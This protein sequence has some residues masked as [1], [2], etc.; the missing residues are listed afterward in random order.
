MGC[1]RIV[2]VTVATL[3]LLGSTAFTDVHKDNNLGFQVNTPAN[4]KN[5]PVA[6]TE[7]WI[8]A[9]YLSPKSYTSRKDAY[10]HTPDMK[11]ILFPEAVVKDRGV[12]VKK[13]DDKTSVIQIKNPYKDFKAYLAA[14]ASGGGF[15]I[16]KEEETTVAGVA[17]TCYEIK[18]EKLTVPRRSLAWVYHG[19]DADWAV[20]FEALEDH[21][22]KLSPDYVA[23]LRSFRFIKRE[24]SVI[25]EGASGT[26]ADDII[27]DLSKLSAE[28][29]AKRRS[30]KHERDL[31]K[32]VDRLPSGW[33]QKKSRNYVAL[34]HVDEKYTTWSLEQAEAI[35]GW[36]E[37]T[38]GWVG[39]GKAG[40]G[41]IRICEGSDEYRA[42]VDNSGGFWSASAE[43]VTY[44]DV[45]AG[46]RSNAVQS[47][48]RSIVGLWFADKNPHFRWGV[49]GW[50]ETGLD[51]FLMTAT[52][53]GGSLTFKADEWETTLMRETGKAGKLVKPRDLIRMSLEEFYRT[54]NS[55]PQAGAFV[56]YLLDGPGK[57]GARSKNFLRDYVKA[58]VSVLDEENA[59]DR[60]E[61]RV[62]DRP[63]TEEEEEER[64]KERRKKEKQRIQTV[65]DRAFPSWS[66]SDWQS[67]EKQYL[68]YV[69]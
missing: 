69:D 34:S 61:S 14:N 42:F 54:E 52:A 16:S 12:D 13:V 32:S 47:M 43:I 58:L 33:I 4:W 60:A 5:I 21:W 8:V 50:L 25:P 48:N 29:R 46:K 23:C 10:Q 28:E 22:E 27:V 2:V 59:Q 17:T 24:G 66:D 63:K 68:D 3:V 55:M 65:F 11:V 56:R 45:N 49:P 31:R 39:D 20:M 53:K 19:P 9:K 35:R 62:S 7:T 67:F 15:F 26:G 41:I 18:Y 64:F 57:T 51:Q 44:K 40:P 36:L 38:F 37:K 6:S 1:T 30:E